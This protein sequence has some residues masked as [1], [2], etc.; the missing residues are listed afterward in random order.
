MPEGE[1]DR[2]A[3]L[4]A[5]AV[6]VR[7]TL[8]KVSRCSP[9]K[10]WKREK[11]VDDEGACFEN[12]RSARESPLSF[13]GTHGG[14]EGAALR[15]LEMARSCDFCRA[16]CWQRRVCDDEDREGKSRQQ[17]LFEKLRGAISRKHDKKLSFASCSS[18]N[19]L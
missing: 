8:A 11:E 9:V 2:C 18:Q 13:A 19:N 5:M 15:R 4:R 12:G 16:I 14:D 6:Q 3:G 17:R 1:G 10:E 7:E